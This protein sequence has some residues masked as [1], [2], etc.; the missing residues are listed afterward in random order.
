M[1]ERD[2]NQLLSIAQIVEELKYTP[3]KISPQSLYQAIS[4][5]RLKSVRIG[6]FISVRRSELDEFLQHR[7]AKK[8]R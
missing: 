8:P 4:E 1:S 5:G 2:P 3:D 7:R 6:K